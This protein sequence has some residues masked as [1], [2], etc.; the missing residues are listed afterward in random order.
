MAKILFASAFFAALCVGCAAPVTDDAAQNIDPAADEASIG[1]A[2]AAEARLAEDARLAAAEER[3]RL[4][5]ESFP[6][7]RE[8]FEQR[9]DELE[10]IINDE[11]WVRAKNDGEALQQELLPLFRSSISE[12]PEVV[13]IRTR[14]DDALGVARKEEN[15]LRRQATERATAPVQAQ[16]S[17]VNFVDEFGDVTNQGARSTP[18][19]SLRPM[20]F[21]YGDIEAQ[22]FVNC[23]RAWI[24]FSDTPNLTGGNTRDGYTSYSAAVR[25]DGNDVGAWVVQQSWGD[26]DLR[27]LNNSQ[28]ISV[29]SSASTFALALNWF[30]EGSVAFRWSLTGSSDA[31]RASCD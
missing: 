18:V 13:S 2:S 31:I 30:G 28:A 23:D 5:A 16:W 29:L 27:F 24:R 6:T 7:R 3:A 9:L 21:P 20:S 14:L 22:V 1:A 25:V 26:N 17:R 8:D 15:V 11:A 4:A 12:T 10:G 19:G